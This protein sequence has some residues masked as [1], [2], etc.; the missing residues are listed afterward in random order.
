MARTG[1]AVHGGVS[2]PDH[3]DADE[4]SAATRKGMTT[5]RPPRLLVQGLAEEY[6][7]QKEEA[8]ALGLL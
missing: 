3:P 8:I 1:K 5:R 2:W 7:K 6:A 4:G